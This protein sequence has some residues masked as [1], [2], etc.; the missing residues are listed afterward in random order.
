MSWSDS[1]IAALVEPDRVHRKAYVDPDIFELEME[2]IF[3]RLW[4]YVGHESQVKNPGD[5]YLA[6]IGRQPMMMVRDRRGDIHV[7][8]NRCPHRGA[9]ICSARRGNAG[10]LFRCSRTAMSAPV[11]TATTPP[12][13]CG[14]RRGPTTT[15]AS[16]SRRWPPTAPISKPIS[17][18]RRPPSTSSST[19]PRPANARWSATASA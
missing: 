8:Y 11:S 19:A 7:L 13:A 4:I 5:F 12:S 15:A 14:R 6:R 1:D 17:A 3:E 16:G 9:R 2:R 18:A 10:D